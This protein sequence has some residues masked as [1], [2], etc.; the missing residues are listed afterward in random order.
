MLIKKWKSHLTENKMTYGEHFLFAVG[1]GF[2]CILAGFY[3]IVHGLFPCFYQ[4]AG[5]NLVHKLNNAFEQ[6]SNK[7]LTLEQNNV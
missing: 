7:N 5:S 2:H 4:K 1:H 3:L 6:N